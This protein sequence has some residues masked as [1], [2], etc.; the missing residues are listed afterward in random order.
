[1][2]FVCAPRLGGGALLVLFPKRD[3]FLP[4]NYRQIAII[5]AL[6]KLYS[7]LVLSSVKTAIDKA[8]LAV[9][10]AGFRDGMLCADH[11]HAVRM[12]AE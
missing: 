9:E 1:M 3:P 4:K 2:D 10:Q 11:V 5:P 12:S 8:L 7:M 6:G